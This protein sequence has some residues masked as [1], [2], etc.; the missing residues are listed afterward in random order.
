MTQLAPDSSIINAQACLSLDEA[1]E[2]CRK[3]TAQ[4]A[5]TFYLGTMLLPSIKRRAIWA[6]YVWCR[7]TDAVSYT[8]L[9]LPTKA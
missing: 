9:T 4:W 1:Y 2:A 3:E 5:K 7:R 8:H 6:I